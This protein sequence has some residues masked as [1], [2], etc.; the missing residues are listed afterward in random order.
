MILRETE[1]TNGW[2]N[3][4]V[5]LHTEAE[6]LFD[7]RNVGDAL[8]IALWVIFF[9]FVDVVSLIRPD[10]LVLWRA[11]VGM[12]SQDRCSGSLCSG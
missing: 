6:T 2:G 10:L 1:R 11:C 5:G 9:H 4:N 3:D 8:A 7:N 12:I